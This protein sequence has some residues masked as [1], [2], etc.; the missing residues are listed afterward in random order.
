MRPIKADELRRIATADKLAAL[1]SANAELVNK[2]LEQRSAY[3]D[4]HGDL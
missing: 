4:A 3:I 1:Q 2:T